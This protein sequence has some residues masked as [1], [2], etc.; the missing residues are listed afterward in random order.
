MRSRCLNQ[1]AHE[2]N[3]YGGRGI[4]ICGEWLA[5]FDNFA[6]WAFESGY[7]EGLTIDRINNDGNYEP[8]NCRWITKGEQNRNKR[9]NVM[10]EY[11]GEKKCIRDWYRELN[12]PYCAIRKRIARG[13]SA[14][15]A[16]T[17]PL[18]D[19][20]NT[21]SRLAAEHGISLGILYNRVNKLGWDLDEALNTPPN[22]VDRTSDEFFLRHYGRKCC[23]ICGKE[24]IARNVSMK[25]CC[26]ACEAKGFRRREKA[27]KAAAA[28]C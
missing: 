1:N 19:H 12:L 3:N 18:F 21:M 14:E 8:D 26:Q 10:I 23:P 11:K 16:F 5:D 15:K 7:A 2:Y 6:D 13:W 17:T 20:Q 25:Y 4:V 27:R 9:T 24:F 28:A 22:S